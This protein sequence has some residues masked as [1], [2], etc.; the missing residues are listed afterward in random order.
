MANRHDA[1]IDAFW[2]SRNGLAGATPVLDAELAATI[3]Q[4][5]TLYASSPPVST[6]ER[7]RKRVLLDPS[8]FATEN[9]PDMNALALPVTQAARPT[10]R[11]T[12]TLA[13]QRPSL[14]LALAAAAV[15]LFASLGGWFAYERLGGNDSHPA[16]I[17]AATQS[18][19][20]IPD[21]PMYRNTPGRTG[22]MPG[23]GPIGDPVP[24]L[25][26]NIG[27]N[28]A[29]AVVVIDGT[30]YSMGDDG[31]L[32]A[33]DAV[34][35]RERWSV[36]MASG[37]ADITGGDGLV[38]AGASDGTLSALDAA[39]GTARWH[40]PVGD[41]AAVTAPIDGALY[42]GGANGIAFALDAA[43]GEEQ[44]RVQL[45]PV[46]LRGPAANDDALFY[47]SDD[48]RLIAVDRASGETLWTYEAGLQIVVTPAV[49]GGLVYSSPRND[50]TGP[51]VVVALDATTGAEVWRSAPAEATNCFTPAIA[52]GVA[53]TNCDNGSTY[54]FDAG[55]GEIIWQTDL[56]AATIVSATLAIAADTLYEAIDERVIRALDIADGTERWRY[57]ADGWPGQFAITGGMIYFGS[58]LGTITALGGTD[59]PNAPAGLA[60]PIPAPTVDASP[61]PVANASVAFTG[62]VIAADPAFNFLLNIDADGNRYLVDRDTDQL[63][64]VAPDGT[65][66]YTIGGS[67]GPTA[68]YEP[69]SLVVDDAGN[70]Y[71]GNNQ[72]DVIRKFDAAGNFLL[73]FGS[74]GN[75][76]GEFA[77]GGVPG[78]IDDQGRLWVSDFGNHRVQVFDLDGHFLF[79]FGAFGSAPGKLAHPNRVAL[80]A[81]GNVYVAE[82]DTRRLSKFAPDG[83]F[84]AAWGHDF[85]CLAG[86]AVDQE[87]GLVYV[88]DA[89]NSRVQV[90]DTEG[91]FVTM[92]GSPDDDPGPLVAP[93]LITLDGHGSIYLTDIYTVQT[94]QFQLLPPLWPE[95]TPTA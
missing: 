86:V 44:W 59:D 62:Y 8:S 73:E 50:N 29:H 81:D 58:A 84:I 48:G 90:L 32:H 71:V 87:H 39:T 17:P 66:L 91:N 27:D 53:Y 24:F 30:V 4:L 35:G 88:A 56:G 36:A 20:P 60:T 47:G 11:T 94:S 22:L 2:D 43:T 12:P 14:W 34:T 21:M 18:A 31:V 15:I 89:D 9:A 78:G 72:R 68:L 6:R 92:W 16:V 77:G 64:K 70:I 61:S 82:C 63:A 85:R 41:S 26:V 95:G 74:T 33:F 19:S 28:A 67:S 13:R 79:T 76:E 54:A 7:V 69:F 3:Q 5:H 57:E 93:L 38:F 83:T 49:A 65:T 51:S 52:D 45:S 42:G 75:G 37:G 46:S 25:T 40:Y 23:P 80:D 1:N 55:S 10:P